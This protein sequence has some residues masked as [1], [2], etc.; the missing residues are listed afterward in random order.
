MRHTARTSGVAREQLVVFPVHCWD[1][2]CRSPYDVFYTRRILRSDCGAEHVYS[3]PGEETSSA[4]DPYSALRNW[5]RANRVFASETE[6]LRVSVKRRWSDTCGRWYWSFGCPKCGALFGKH[7]FFSQLMC[8]AEWHDRA[9]FCS[10]EFACSEHRPEPH[11]C[12]PSNGAFCSQTPRS[13]EERYS[14]AVICLLPRIARFRSNKVSSACRVSGAR[15]YDSLSAGYCLD[16]TSA[17]NPWT[18]W[19]ISAP[20]SP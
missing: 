15:W 20:A 16:K 4:Q 3:D 17:R 8:S 13:S 10:K 18:A 2:Y 14:T 9:P 12:F 7:Y 6:H 19:V 1:R 11:W 5:H